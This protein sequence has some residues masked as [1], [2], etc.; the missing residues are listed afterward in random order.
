MLG[1][2]SRRWCL[3][4][5][6]I[7]SLLCVPPLGGQSGA[8]AALA[9]CDRTVS[10]RVAPQAFGPGNWCLTGADALGLTVAPGARVWITNSRIVGPVTISGAEF[11]K[12]CGSRVTKTLSISGS[13]GPVT[14]G[15]TSAEDCARNDLVGVDIRGNSAGVTVSNNR[16]A[17]DLICTGNAPAPDAGSSA[18]VVAGVTDCFDEPAFET[19]PGTTASPYSI[20]G[21]RGASGGWLIPLDSTPMPGCPAMQVMPLQN[22]SGIPQ[23]Y[24]GPLF[25]DGQPVEGCFAAARALAGPAN[26]GGSDN[27]AHRWNNGIV[28]NFSRGAWGENIIMKADNLGLPAFVVRT[29]MWETYRYNNGIDRLGY[30]IGNEYASPEGGAVQLF[31]RGMILWWQGGGKIV[32]AKQPDS[33]GDA[34]TKYS[35]DFEWTVPYGYAGRNCTDY[36]A[37]RMAT[38]HPGF[39]PSGLG[40]GGNWGKSLAAKGWKTDNMPRPG[41]I[42]WQNPTTNPWG[43][44][45]Y[46]RAVNADG[47]LDIEDFNATKPAC[48]YR[49]W[50]G[51]SRVNVKTF[52]GYAH[53]PA[54]LWN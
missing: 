34:I 30:P 7:L 50:T 11:L 2:V 35:C 37:W 23:N 43:H 21:G 51:A 14:V 44:V 4:T 16:I 13:T 9:V 19:E 28:Q 53:P 36:A 10:G 42:A 26:V 45:A 6:A 5:A 40:H 33:G 1:R 47:T 49:H 39:D 52:S 22:A 15:G 46:V 29:G 24:T 3:Y 48:T 25:V 8:A 38:D 27:G 32:A 20:G 54:A 31:E 18:N 41:D 17:A 12:I